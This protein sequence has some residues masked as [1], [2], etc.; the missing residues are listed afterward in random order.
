MMIFLL[1]IYICIY[2]YYIGL[3]KLG[4]LSLSRTQVTNSLLILL[5]DFEKTGFTRSLSTLN[6]AQCQHISD[7]GIRGLKG[8]KKFIY[9]HE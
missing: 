9:I 1:M 6:L 3:T 8:K 4:T 5:G 7:I 2:I